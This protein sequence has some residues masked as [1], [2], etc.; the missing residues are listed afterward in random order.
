V[1]VTNQKRSMTQHSDYVANLQ[2]GF[3]SPSRVHSASIVYNSF[4]E[5]VFFAGRDGAPDAYEQPFNSLDLVYSFFP[6]DLLT[7]KFRAQNLLE[8]KLEVERRNVVTLQQ[9]VGITFK[10]DASMK[11]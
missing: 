5:R 10:L 2:L 7:I 4:G 11:F 6:S 1:S 8:E 3:D 9:D